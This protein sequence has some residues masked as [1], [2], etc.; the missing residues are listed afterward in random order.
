MEESVHRIPVWDGQ[1]HT[2]RKFLRDMAWF[3]EGED[4]TRITYN[5][6]ARVVQRQV[7][8]VRR[9]GEEF[10]PTELR[11]ISALKWT[12]EAAA[13]HSARSKSSSSRR[14]SST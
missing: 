5:L 7:G 4:I 3:L 14:R 6:A 12:T 1:P 11:H 8:T 10:D 13:E 9:R 2:F